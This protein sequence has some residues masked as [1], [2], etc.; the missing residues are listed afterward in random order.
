[1]VRKAAL[2]VGA[3]GMLGAMALPAQADLKMCNN[4]TSRVGVALGYK[5]KEGWATEGWWT[6]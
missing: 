6:I 3:L 4:T 1:M 5:D 2:T